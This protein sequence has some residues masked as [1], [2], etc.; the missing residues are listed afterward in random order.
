MEIFQHAV[1]TV[2][3]LAAGALV[4]RRVFGF[5][6]PRA[7]APRCAGCPSTQSACAP[8]ASQAGTGASHPA[9]LVRRADL[10]TSALP[11]Q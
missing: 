2:V 6:S 11:R 1:V 9:V 10:R 4:L 8:A 3:A 5:L 7:E